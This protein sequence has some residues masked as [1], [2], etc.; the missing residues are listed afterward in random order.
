MTLKRILLRVSAS[1]SIKKKK[2][3]SLSV[4]LSLPKTKQQNLSHTGKDSAVYGTKNGEA[5]IRTLEGLASLT[6]FKTAAFNHS[7]TSPK[8][9][10]EFLDF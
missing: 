1:F 9:L 4:R 6:V 10:N 2:S 3:F 7:A 5:E 8:I